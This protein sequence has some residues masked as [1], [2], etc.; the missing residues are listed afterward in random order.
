[1]NIAKN[2]LMGLTVFVL[3][4][5]ATANSDKPSGIAALKDDVRLGEKVEK[6]CFNRNID[7][8]SQAGRKT[9]VLSSGVNKDYIV[10]IGGVCPNLASA[11]SIGLDSSQSCVRRGDYLI[12]SDS[13]FGLHDNTGFGPD[14]CYI[15][16][17]HKWDKRAAA[18]V[19]VETA[20]P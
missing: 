5:C 11:Q 2:T 15:D 16:S 14:R 3:T 19:G 17:I 1:M 4:A 10:Q 6:I 8:F 12:V 18:K 9:V 20:E 7:G 13:A